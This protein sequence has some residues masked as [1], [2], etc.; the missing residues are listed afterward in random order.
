VQIR[1]TFR[2]FA[3]LLL[4]CSHSQAV[5]ATLDIE[6]TQGISAKTPVAVIPFAGQQALDTNEQLADV[7]ANDLNISGRFSILPRKDYNHNPSRVMEVQAQYWRDKNVDNIIVGEVKAVADHRFSVKVSL[8]DLYNN[9]PIRRPESIYNRTYVVKAKDVRR[10]AHRF[11]D[12]IYST[13]TDERGIFSTRIAY[14]VVKHPTSTT[15]EY[16]LE[17]ADMDGVNPHTLMRSN[18]SIMSPDWSADGRYLSFVS[19]ENGR[20]EVFVENVITG[21]RR[22]I[23]DFKGI[24]SAPAWSPDGKQLALVLSKTGKPKIY[25]YHIAKRTFKQLTYGLSIDTEPSWAR[26]GKTIVFTSNRGGSPQVYRYWL[27]NQKVKRLT[28]EGRYN[29][30]P[31]LTSDAKNLV[32]LHHN[33]KAFTIAVQELANGIV[34]ELTRTNSNESPTVSPNGRMVLY[35]TLDKAKGVLALVSIDGRVRLRLPSLEGEVQ[36]PAWSPLARE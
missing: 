2:A 1:L 9:N 31:Q 23:A 16:R 15:S 36:E 34:S 21:Q 24:N 10:V 11:A 20:S 19:F 13:L 5:F 3:A 33:G 29:A 27:K 25:L 4:L 22:K 35:A 12:E 18:H 8:L 32:F 26:D 30:S 17:V 7:I 6:L 28:F 14:V